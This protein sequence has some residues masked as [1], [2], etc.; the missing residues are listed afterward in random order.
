M[1]GPIAMMLKDE[2]IN[3]NLKNKIFIFSQI[4][5]FVDRINLL[6]ID[7]LDLEN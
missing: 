3:E 6:S 4:G 2:V 7:E 5:Q 1:G